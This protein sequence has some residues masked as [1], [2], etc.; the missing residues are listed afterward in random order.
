[1]FVIF[2]FIKY[3]NNFFCIFVPYLENY[4]FTKQQYDHEKN[5]FAYS[6]VKSLRDA[7]CW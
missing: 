4:K 1:M 3:K 7:L 2:S 6:D 5:H